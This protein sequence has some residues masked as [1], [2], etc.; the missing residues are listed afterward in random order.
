M[1]R[2]LLFALS[3][4]ALLTASGE[5]FRPTFHF[6]PAKNWTNDPNGA[7][8][9]RGEYHL[10]YQY[11]PFGDVWGHMSWGHAVSKDLLHWNHLPIA[12]AE[13][14]GAM[15]FSGSVVVDPN[16]SGLCIAS[17]DCLIAIYTSHTPALQTQHIAVSN[18]LGRTWKKYAANPVIDLGMKDFRDPKVFRHA[19]KWVMVVAIPLEQKVRF[20]ASTDLK[21]W[22]VLSDF[23]P[24]GATNG[25]WE[26]PDLF[27]LP[28]SGE[29][30]NSKWVLSVNV[31]PGA[32]AGGSGN[33]YFIG[34]F[35][36][37]NFRNS[38]SA[39]VKLWA[40][41]GKDF[42][43][44]TSFSD[45]PR[46]DGRR[47][48]IAWFSNWLY[49]REEPTS[50]FRGIM[51]V[52]R[53][54]SLR[55]TKDGLRLAQTPVAEL[56]KLRRRKIEMHE[57]TIAQANRRLER[58]AST[59]YEL[60]TNLSNASLRLR[61]GPEGEQTLVGFE[62]D[63][64]FMDRTHSGNVGF[65]KEFPGIHRAPCVPGNV[66]VLVD[67]SSVEIFAGNGEVVMSDRIFPSTRSTGLQF[68]GVPSARISFTLWT[69][70]GK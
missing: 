53:T 42:Y 41:W 13:E 64:L 19:D 45:V 8:Y 21:K 38:N 70:A 20:F 17:P 66:R 27:P 14:N 25:A 60:Q 18:D 48:W 12:L 1:T 65:N 29:S 58:F 59:A 31:N 32:S 47:I 30:G 5:Q 26:C 46:K 22:D 9:Y 10:F 44:S 67:S 24:Q 39:D 69:L 7:V 56:S 62:K 15:I 35:D 23:G 4:M 3:S 57:V 50:P 6:S 40:D 33:Q 43:A 16:T 34:E 37:K 11:N 52:P 36:G 49:A 28:V 54:L 63:K 55:Q 61:I 2:L 51:T 68:K